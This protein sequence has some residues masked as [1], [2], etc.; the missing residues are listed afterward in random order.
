M[1]RDLEHSRQRDIIYI[2][3]ATGQQ[4][5]ILLA[6]QSLTDEAGGHPRND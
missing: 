6:R 2:G 1:K 4:S 3:A 5:P